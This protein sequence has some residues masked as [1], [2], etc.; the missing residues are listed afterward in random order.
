RQLMM[1]FQ[2]EGALM[3]LCGASLGLLLGI[4]MARMALAA[5]GKT[6]SSLYVEVHA[7]QISI[8]FWLYMAVPLGGMAMAWFASWI[9]AREANAVTPR[10]AFSHVTLHQHTRHNIVPF[11]LAG[12]LAL[13]IGA[14]LCWPRIS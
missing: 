6:V 13:A 5:V 10:M 11:T 1:L 14:L 3:G 12:L 8:P 7:A 4:W 2:S 9:S